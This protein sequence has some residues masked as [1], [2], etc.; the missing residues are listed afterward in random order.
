MQQHLLESCSRNPIT[1]ELTP[2]LILYI[3]DESL[4][5]KRAKS[6]ATG[7]LRELP[8]M[9]E[10]EAQ[11]IAQSVVAIASLSLERARAEELGLHWYQ[12]EAAGNSC[13]HKSHGALN[14]AL[15][16]WSDPPAPESLIGKISTDR[17]HPGEAVRCLCV[18]LPITDLREV[19]WPAKVFWQGRLEKM[20]RS[21]F[22]AIWG[23]G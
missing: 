13:V 8:G 9:A 19:S 18:P 1:R 6:I 14:I 2:A 17:C 10:S 5:G 16:R 21:Q 7:I 4:K 22:R 20:K 15:V 12:W 3:Q 11:Q 23:Q